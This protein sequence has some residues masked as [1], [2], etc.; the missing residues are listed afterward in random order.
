MKPLGLV[1]AVHVI[2]IA[3]SLITGSV[4]NIT[5]ASTTGIVT[6]FGGLDTVQKMSTRVVMVITYSQV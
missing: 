5:P 1:G 3:V 6:R 2:L 4:V